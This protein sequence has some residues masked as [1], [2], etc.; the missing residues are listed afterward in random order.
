MFGLSLVA[1]PEL[2]PAEPDTMVKISLNI[3][4]LWVNEKIVQKI[5]CLENCLEYCSK[6]WVHLY[7]K[8]IKIQN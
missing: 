2:D 8:E 1:P 3:P 4:I 6:N 5:V 7:K